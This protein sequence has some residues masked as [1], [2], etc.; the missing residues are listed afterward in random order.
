MRVLLVAL[1]C[2]L[3]GSQLAWGHAALVTASPASGSVLAQ[4]PAAV[5]LTFSEPVGV[6]AAQLVGP[7]GQSLALGPVQDQGREV[8]IPVPEDR[9]QGTYL[10]SWRV[11]STDGHP[12]GGTLDYAIGASS[13]PVAA[14]GPP[15]S[16]RSLAIWIVRWLG[17]LCLFTAVGAAL[18]R[19]LDANGRNTWSRPAIS[20]GV[21]LLPVSLGLQGLDL[22]DAPWA[23]LAQPATW[24]QALASTY[25]ATLGLAAIGFGAAALAQ[26]LRPRGLFLGAALAS[27][28]FAGMALA[29]SGHAGTAPPQWLSRPAV[30]LHVMMAIAW[31]G[32]LMPLSRLLRRPLEA[33]GGHRALAR[34]SCWITP[35]VALLVLSGALLSVLQLD[36]VADLWHTDYG[37]VLTAKLCLVGLLFCLAAYNRWRL[38]GPVLAG[39]GTARSRLRSA[40]RAEIVLAVVILAVVALWRFTPPPRS[41][42]SAPVAVASAVTLADDRVQV[43]LEPFGGSW[44]IHLTQPDGKPFIAQSVAVAVGAPDAGI[45]PVR[46]TAQRQADGLWRIALPVLPSNGRAQVGV[47]VLVDDFDQITLQARW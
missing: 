13:A 43:V 34:F 12:V 11:V 24:A 21:V 4:A 47:T 3:T 5:V 15:A 16:A 32:V 35:V 41:L 30:A 31:I 27:L 10:L 29:V 2:L 25:A 23:A 6:T 28:L 39:R 44:T 17:Y 45:E 9:A 20:L 22:R 8:R 38:T 7:D 46:R 14:A 19:F 18:S 37:R 42:A 1:G 33:A 36:R 40:I 26:V